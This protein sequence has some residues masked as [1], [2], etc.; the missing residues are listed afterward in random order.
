MGAFGDYSTSNS[1]SG[2]LNLFDMISGCLREIVSKGNFG[3]VKLRDDITSE[4]D[5]K[6]SGFSCTEQLILD[7][8]MPLAQICIMVQE[9]HH[10]LN[11]RNILDQFDRAM[12]P[13]K[14]VVKPSIKTNLTDRLARQQ[15]PA[16][17]GQAVEE[18]TK[19]LTPQDIVSEEMVGRPALWSIV[20][21]HPDP[22]PVEGPGVKSMLSRPANGNPFSFDAIEQSFEYLIDILTGQT[23]KELMEMYEERAKGKTES[24]PNA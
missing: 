1:S 13:P 17:D 4:H 7:K 14:E 19:K 20:I 6:Q 2:H 15:K 12:N 21:T 5:T 10:N 18:P 22:H 23:P 11:I 9:S 24:A 3:S 16:D 8:G